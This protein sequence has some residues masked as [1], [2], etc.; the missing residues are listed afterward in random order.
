MHIVSE[1]GNLE[2]ARILAN[3]MKPA[4]KSQKSGIEV[5][6]GIHSDLQ[7]MTTSRMKG[8]LK[9]EKMIRP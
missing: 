5:P 3:K 7:V 6:C 9:C 1:L 8:F 2:V 4:K